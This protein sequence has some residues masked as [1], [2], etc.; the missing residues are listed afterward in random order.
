MSLVGSSSA[1]PELFLDPNPEDKGESNYKDYLCDLKSKGIDYSSFFDSDIYKRACQRF[2]ERS[3]LNVDYM[4]SDIIKKDY[5]E[6][7]IIG[8]AFVI[9]HS[10]RVDNNIC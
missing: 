3:L 5:F 6:Q 10:F 4:F 7:C 2:F 1:I 9:G 8:V